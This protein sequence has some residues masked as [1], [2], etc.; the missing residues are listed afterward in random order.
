M[1]VGSGRRPV[2]KE[3]SKKPLI[4]WCAVF[5]VMLIL[6][7]VARLSTAFS[8]WYAK[9]IFCPVGG[10]VSRVT[11]V[12]PFS[13]GEYI[14]L[15]GVAL[16]AIGPAAVIILVIFSRKRKKIL[17]FAGKF[18]AWTAL[19]VFTLMTFNCSMMY[20]CRTISEKYYS[21][22]PEGYTAE[23]L[24]GLCVYYIENLNSLSA[25]IERGDDGMMK[26]DGVMEKCAEA[27]NAQGANF[28]RL[29]GSYP[30][31][32]PIRSSMLLTQA[33]I[34]GV[35]FP[36]TLEANYNTKVTSV[37]IPCTVCHELSHLRGYMLEDEANFLAI[38]ATTS[39]QYN[40]LRYSGYMT[41]FNY[42]MNEL[43][44]YVPAEEYNE[45][46]AMVNEQVWTDNIYITEEYK[47][48]IEDEAVLSTEKVSE[49]EEKV[50]DASLKMN[51]V[52]D[53]VN[54]YNRVV[55]LLLDDYYTKK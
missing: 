10:A 1:Y 21:D 23:Q 34:L 40:E 51:G 39:S 4:V 44:K 48:Q 42:S 35:Y 32:K 24:K 38:E 9:Y 30:K 15:A 45:V 50:N 36:F 12:L 2:K 54:S 41:A 19:V 55:A 37:K 13:L 7:V 47:K 28:D 53:G 20:H 14:L 31:A 11:G 5:A 52:E 29:S 8:D 3:K 16:L 26:V 33:D 6:N 17:A 22:A 49:F 27:M 46:A 25:K 18:I 43:V